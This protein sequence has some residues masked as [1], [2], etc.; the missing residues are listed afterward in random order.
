M[1][2]AVDEQ[3]PVTVPAELAH[4]IRAAVA[5]GD[6]ASSNEVVRDALAEWARKRDTQAQKHAALKA[7]IDRGLD[8]LAAGRVIEFAPERIAARGRQV[9]QRRSR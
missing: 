2:M 7:D 5:H 3:L 1:A 4:T 8:D 9:L 6:Y